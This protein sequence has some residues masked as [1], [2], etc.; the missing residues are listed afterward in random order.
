MMA[1]AGKQMNFAG[2]A[3]VNPTQSKAKTDGLSLE[4]LYSH[5]PV[6]LEDTATMRR[7]RLCCHGFHKNRLQPV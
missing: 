6:G 1:N 3:S 2:G 5:R 4:L 7:V